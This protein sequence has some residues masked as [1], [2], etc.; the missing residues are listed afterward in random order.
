MKASI[1][2]IGNSRG[3]RIPRPVLDQ[4]QFTDVVEMEVRDGDLI[5]RASANSRDGW[6]DAFREMACQNDDRLLDSA[7]I[8]SEW[9]DK[10][11]EW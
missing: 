2:K 11:W 5:I 7:P 8:S 4:C 1:T 10:E 9:D 3:I 6:D